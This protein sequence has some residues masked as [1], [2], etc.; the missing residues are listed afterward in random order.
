MRTRIAFLLLL[1]LSLTLGLGVHPCGA[2]AAE[3]HAGA[4]V[5]KMESKAPA[6]M[7]SCHARMAHAPDSRK[8]VPRSG[9]CGSEPGSDHHCPHFCHATAL[10][11]VT[12]PVLTMQ[13]VAELAVEP[14][15]RALAA[16]ARSIDHVPL[17]R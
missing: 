16:P 17:S 9:S 8:P 3:Q 2:A 5:L 12:P 10:A 11:A 15:E 14:A 4:T 13:V 6:A 7:P 1:T